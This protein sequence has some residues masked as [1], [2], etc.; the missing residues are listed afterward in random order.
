MTKD[1]DIIAKYSRKYKTPYQVQQL[2]NRFHYNTS[3]TLCSALTTLKRKSAHCLE[4]VF[5][6]AALLEHHGYEPWVLSLESQDK[7][8][9][10]LFVFQ[11]NGR[12]GAVGKSRDKGLAG[13]APIFNNLRNLAWSYFDPYVDGTGKVTA[14]QVAHLDEISSNWRK[15]P[16]NVWKLENYL[17]EI[18]HHPVNFS[19]KRYQALLRDFHKGLEP[20]EQP[21]WW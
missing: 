2:L 19:K 21:H 13:R 18:F 4:G 20:R 15:S 1:K 16:Q 10:C 5:V 14:W 17:L 11:E 9:H 3:S 12:W 6:A 8:D 7:L